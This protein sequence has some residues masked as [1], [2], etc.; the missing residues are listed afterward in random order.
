MR[1]HRRKLRRG[2]MGAHKWS[3]TS[4]IAE[5]SVGPTLW[6]LSKILCLSWRMGSRS[7]TGK[8]H[9]FFLMSAWISRFF[10]QRSFTEWLPN[11]T[12]PKQDQIYAKDCRLMNQ[13]R[14][15]AFLFTFIAIFL[16]P[17]ASSRWTE[18]GCL[19]CCRAQAGAISNDLTVKAVFLWSFR[20]LGQFLQRLWPRDVFRSL[21]FSGC[22]FPLWSLDG[23]HIINIWGA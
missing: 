16:P 20:A 12:C 8:C 10:H 2:F 18:I 23:K 15:G 13:K 14:N 22:L 19:L 4:T 1:R 3:G 7:L 11:M 21:V 17:L 5:L 6:H 9:F